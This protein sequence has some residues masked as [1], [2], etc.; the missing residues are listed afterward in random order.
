MLKTF[1]MFKHMSVEGEILLNERQLQNLQ[2]VLIKMLDDFD[3]FCKKE[4]LEYVLCGGNCLGAVRHEGFIPWDDDLD[5]AITRESFDKLV[6]RF[7]AQMGNKYILQIPG[8]T[9]GYE[10]GFARIR[11]KGTLVR[12]KEDINL[13]DSQCGAYI[14][15]FILENL[16]GLAPLRL[17]HGIGSLA[18]GLALSCRRFAEHKDDYY[19]M[20]GSEKRGRNAVRLKSTLGLLVSFFS[21]SKW[22]EIW[23]RWNSIIKNNASV[24]I[25]IP[26]GRGHYFKETYQR[27]SFFPA[28][29]WRFGDR[30][31]P[32]PNDAKQYLEKLY[33]IDFMVPPP[34][35]SREKHAVLS[36]DLGSYSTTN[37]K[38]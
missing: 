22:A 17:L 34:Q 29:Y 11:L 19:S 8:V 5:L 9:P 21:I 26:T 3:D 7:D 35:D 1:E 28:S 24:N 33:G 13:P 32:L 2:A 31:F 30:D 38:V 15:L 20:M 36:F 4:H 12:N 6:E 16:P 25:G 23:D 14:D 18:L 27:S 37:K 10:L